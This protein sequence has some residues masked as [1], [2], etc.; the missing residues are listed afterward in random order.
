VIRH[1]KIAATTVVALLFLAGIAAAA[2]D[3]YGGARKARDHGF[4]HGYRDGFRQG[5][6]D[7]KANVKPTVDSQDFRNADLGYEEYM[8]SR[9]DFQD[10]YRDGYKS[11]YDDGYNNRPVRADVYGVRGEEYD[12]DRVPRRDEDDR[13]AKWAYTDVATDIGYRDGLSAGQ[14][15]LRNHK[16]YRPEKHD[17]YKDADHGFRKDYGDKNLYKEQYRKGFMRGYEDAFHSRGR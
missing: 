8:G 14:A 9:E 5:R 2:Q 16:E 17:A 12:P 6:A 7:L 13:Y 11:G 3:D 1:L 4:Q 10:G 15:D